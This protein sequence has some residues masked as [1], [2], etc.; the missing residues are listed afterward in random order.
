[1][2]LM[3]DQVSKKASPC[4]VLFSTADWDAPYWTNKQ[5]TAKMLAEYGWRVL[6]VESI[7]LRMPKAG[8][9]KDLARL[10][11]RLKKGI[12]GVLRGPTQIGDNVWLLSPLVVPATHN[13]GIL[14]MV[15]RML[16]SWPISRFLK[17]ENF[18]EPV[19]WTYHP[20]ILDKIRNIDCGKLLFHCVDD[21]SAIPGIDKKSYLDAEAILLG[22]ADVVV[23]TSKTLEERCSKLNK[24]TYYF[25]NVV[26]FDHFSKAF[27]LQREPEEL[28]SIP[29]PRLIYHGVISDFKLDLDLLV[30]VAGNTPGWNW[31]FIGEERE[32]QSNPKINALRKMDNTYFLGYRCYQDLPLYL[33]ACQVGILP[34]LVNEYT[35]SM[36]PMKYYE[37]L[38]AGLPVV[39]TPLEFTK[40]VTNGLE[41]GETPDEFIEAITRQLS[42]GRLQRSEAYKF[43]GDNTWKARTQK[44]I[45]LLGHEAHK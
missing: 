9:K 28:A 15:N 22:E 6:Y 25:S 7:G 37:Y 43:V 16:L 12:R 4:C 8:S 32:G 38:A 42:R 31:V 44:M 27:D 17:N 10:G 29:C 1:M 33:G 11:K 23:V 21:L 20:Y 41:V 40:H 26:D 18:K 2:S 34:S 5:H 35:K 24:N 45:S 13:G 3:A 30:N 14:A 36:F 39:S 19:I